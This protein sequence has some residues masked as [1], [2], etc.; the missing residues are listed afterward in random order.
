MLL[1]RW[2]LTDQKPL[3]IF[4]NRKWVEPE[5]PI[6]VDQIFFLAKAFILR[7]YNHIMASRASDSKQGC[8]SIFIAIIDAGAWVLIWSWDDH[9][10]DLSSFPFLQHSSIIS[11]SFSPFWKSLACSSKDIAI[12]HHKVQSHRNHCMWKKWLLDSSIPIFLTPICGS[13]K[14]A[15]AL[16]IRKRS[17]P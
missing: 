15:T 8:F 14:S 16:H 11:I 1:S 3:L 7:A 9:C 13:P 5:I 12:D 4:C 2:S 6:W 17:R 10:I